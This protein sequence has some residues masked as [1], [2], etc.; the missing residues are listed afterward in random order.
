MTREEAREQAE[1][2]VFVYFD[3]QTIVS[4]S[5]RLGYKVKISKN[6]RLLNRSEL[7]TKL[8]DYYTD[9]YSKP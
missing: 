2:K 3:A 5:D 6:G 7:E 9:L 1:I 4:V 8:I